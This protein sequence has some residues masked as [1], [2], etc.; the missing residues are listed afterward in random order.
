MT[1]C[2]KLNGSSA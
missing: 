1:T 2:F